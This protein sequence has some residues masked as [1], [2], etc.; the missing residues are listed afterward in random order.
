MN[1][2]PENSG[3]EVPRSEPEIIPPSRAGPRSPFGEAMWSA[4]GRGR[5]HRVSIAKLGPFS[6]ILAALGV[7]LF[8]ALVVFLFAGLLL[9]WIPFGVILMVVSLVSVVFRKSFHR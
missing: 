9:I 3:N 7:I 2:E 1:H 4:S 6:L 5:V 8:L